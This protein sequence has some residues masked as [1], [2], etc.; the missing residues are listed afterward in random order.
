MFSTTCP[1]AASPHISAV[2]SQSGLDFAKDLLVSQAA[3]TL[4]HLSVP[5]IERSVSIPVIGTVSMV[6]SGIVLEGVSVANSTVAA[7]DTGV[8]VSA[9]FSGV[10]LTMEWSYS[11]SSWVVTISDS[12][13]ASIQVEGMDVGVSMGMKNEKGSLKLFVI[14]CG[15][16]MKDLDITLNGGSSWFY[17]GFIDAFSNH[18]RSSVENAITNK[19]MEGAS[20]LDLFLEKLPKEIY[21]DEVAAMNVTFVNDPLFKSS[22]VEFDIDGLFIPSGKTAVRSY[23]HSGDIKFATPLGGCSR[24][25]WLSLDEDV[26]NSISALYFKA[27]LLQHMVDKV[28]DQFLLNTASWRF[29]IPRLYRKYPDK[30]MVL[31]ISA[32]SPPSVKINVG[33]IDATVDLDVTVNILAIGDI[34]PVACISLSV[35]VSGGASVSGNN[36]AGRVGLDYFSF[37]L[38][39]SDIGKLH[40]GIVQS[41]MRIFLKSLFVPY[42]NS[43]LEQGFPL[44]I[45][46]GFIISDAY[47]LISHSRIIVSSDVAFI[48]TM[49][50]PGIKQVYEQVSA[51]MAIM[52]DGNH[53]EA[54]SISS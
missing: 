6:A 42:V 30:N 31:N 9:T 54:S 2:V 29:L 27:G 40:T 41:V 45:I 35:D 43:Y 5:D 13:N 18:I 23:M 4:E 17:Q 22:S 26:F 28:P 12:G 3:E 48:E 47:I 38:K 39:W 7:G 11:Y 19:I 49:K 36:L 14:E 8:V 37:T 15:C 24:M 33:R 10:N 21:V 52:H 51:D 34:V 16:Y 53:H 46:K 20:K 32:I 1:A 25:L 50:K 44:P